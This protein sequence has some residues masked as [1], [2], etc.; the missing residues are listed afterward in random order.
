[1]DKEEMEVIKLEDIMGEQDEEE[2]KSPTIDVDLLQKGIQDNIGVDT[3]DEI[4]NLE[5]KEEAEI[6]EHEPDVKFDLRSLWATEEDGPMRNIIITSILVAS[7]V[8]AEYILV[9]FILKYILMPPTAVQSLREVATLTLYAKL[10]SV[11]TVLLT[12]LVVTFLIP[13]AGK[14]S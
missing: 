14:K 2:G 1:M 13:K 10:A 11:G 7:A 8:V 5:L 4:R 12:L 6:E 3:F 9:Y